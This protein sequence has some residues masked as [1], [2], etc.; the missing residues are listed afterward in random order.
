MFISTHHDWPVKN[1]IS[2]LPIGS[3]GKMICTS[4]DLLSLLGT[5]NKDLG[6][7]SQVLLTGVRLHLRHRLCGLV[8]TFL[9]LNSSRLHDHIR[10]FM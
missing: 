3:K 8:V 1:P 5:Q 2:G 6:A 9:S 10:V 7:A 4:S